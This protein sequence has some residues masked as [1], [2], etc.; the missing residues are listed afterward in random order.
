MP[1][2]YLDRYFVPEDKDIYDMLA[3]CGTSQDKLWTY[4]RNYG[5]LFASTEP[6]TRMMDAIS[7]FPVDR[8]KLLELFQ[9]NSTK[10][11]EEK[12]STKKVEVD[13][14]VERLNAAVAAVQEKRSAAEREEY[15]FEHPAPDVINVKVAYKEPDLSRAEAIQTREKELTIQLVRKDGKLTIRHHSNEKATAVVAD[16]I[17]GLETLTQSKPKVRALDFTG[18]KDPKLRTRFFTDLSRK[19]EGFERQDVPTLKMYRLNAEKSDSAEEEAQEEAAAQVKRMFMAGTDL[20]KSPEYAELEKR[21]FFISAISWISEHQADERMHFEFSAEFTN[22]DA[23]VDVKY[24]CSGKYMRNEEGTLKSYKSSLS[25]I[26]RDSLHGI[27][28]AAAFTLYDEIS[29]PEKPPSGDGNTD[30]MA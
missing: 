29:S 6:R 7:R 25:A 28:D 11:R 13:A 12:F 19:L 30:K 21:G 10:D 3:T 8:Y 4:A 9:L 5:I 26:E 2:Y 18:I 16:I 24:G 1:Q 14:S 15:K 17:K 27:L 20:M 22:P 23:P